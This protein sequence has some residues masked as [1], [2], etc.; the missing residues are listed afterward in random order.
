MAHC[1]YIKKEEKKKK[2]QK[3]TTIMMLCDNNNRRT[4]SAQISQDHMATAFHFL[5]SNRCGAPPALTT[6]AAAGALVY[7]CKQNKTNKK[8]CERRLTPNDIQTNIG[9][10]FLIE[11]LPFK[12]FCVCV[13][14]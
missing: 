11:C 14:V 1:S 3:E 5:I 2:C 10:F 6:A 9:S 8:E 4:V 7:T 12:A 13:C